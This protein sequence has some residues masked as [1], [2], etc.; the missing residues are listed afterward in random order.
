MFIYLFSFD[1]N[2][3]TSPI[4][5]PPAPIREFQRLLVIQ[6]PPLADP[7]LLE[8]DPPLP[9]FSVLDDHLG[10][11]SKP[12]HYNIYGSGQLV[13]RMNDILIDKLASQYKIYQSRW[14]TILIGVSKIINATVLMLIYGWRRTWEDKFWICLGF[15]IFASLTYAVEYGLGWLW[16][17]NF[18][19]IFWRTDNPTKL[20]LCSHS[21]FYSGTFAIKFYVCATG[22]FFQRLG[23]PVVDEVVPFS[24][25]FTEGGL[26]L[27]HVWHE[28]CKQLISKAL[29]GKPKS[30]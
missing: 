3:L 7:P 29:A 5:S 25:I 24:E 8:P 12:A 22:S 6:L 4:T 16:W 15:V 11:M 26:M 1:L 18:R 17:P 21:P 27:E 19:A 23:A 2:F 30:D 9:Q 20:I 28:K 13:R 10:R 14:L